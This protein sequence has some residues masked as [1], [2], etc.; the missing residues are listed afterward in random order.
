MRGRNL[1]GVLA[2]VVAAA[3]AAGYLRYRRDIGQI[4]A[5]VERGG[6]VVR[7]PVGE[8]EYA[9]AGA[10]EPLLVLHGAGGGYDQGLLIPRDLGLDYRLIAPSRFG[11]LRT[12]VPPD[13]SPASQADAYAALLDHLGIDR[14]PVVGVSAGG[15][16]AVELALRHPH[17]VSA[18][19]LLVPRTYDPSQSIH[20][21]ESLRAQVVLRLVEA[22]ADFLFWLA[23]RM[24][25]PWVVRF[26]GVLP[27]VEAAAA[28]AERARVTQVMRTV[29][30]LSRR[31]RGIQVDS[32]IVLSPWPLEEIRI[33][34][35]IV[36]AEDDLYGTLPGA[37]YTAERIPGAELKI[38]PSGGHLMVGQNALLQAWITDFLKRRVGAPTEAA[39][40]S[41]AAG[42]PPVS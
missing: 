25:R 4:S 28:D 6:V 30:P 27:E 19:I 26:L 11:Y 34:V 12:P 29:Q 22:S 36:S 38:L 32:S 9:E 13:P 20:V 1:I 16:G 42:A 15:P 2:T 14:C 23:M 40:A 31:I 17:R 24:A 21:D 10:G 3:G 33:P 5:A 37:R 39:A 18:L 35:L 7:T 8:I 41:P